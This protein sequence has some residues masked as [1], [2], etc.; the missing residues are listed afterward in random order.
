MVFVG[1]RF[2]DDLFGFIGLGRPPR[3]VWSIARW[4]GALL[5]TMLVFAFIYY[6]TPDV[7]HRSFRWITPG[8]GRRRAAV[9]RS[10]RSA[11]RSTSRRV[12]DVGALYGAFAGAIV[13]VGWLWL[14]NVALLF[15]A[16]L[17]AEIEREKE[18]REG[19]PTARRSTGPPARR[20]P[21]RAAP[22]HVLDRALLRRPGVATPNLVALGL[23]ATTTPPMWL[24]TL[25]AQQV[26]GLS[27]AAAGLLFPP[28]NLAVVAGS[29]L[30]PRV[31]AA[32]GARATMAG[33]LAGVAGGALALL[34]IA[35]G[36]AALPSLAGGFVLLGA[37]PRPRVGR[38]DA[39]RDR[40]ARRRPPGLR[41]RPARDER[42]ARHRARAR[43][44]R[45]G[46]GRADGR[47]GRRPR[48]RGVLARSASCSPP[49]SPAPPPS[50]WRPAAWR[51]PARR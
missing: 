15:G 11:S 3:D 29:L 35:P 12:A 23:T 24:C 13:L 19:V 40:G 30:G 41:L 26:L 50:R 39:A 28:F 31:V 33:G 20:E 43:D 49:R 8:R 2:A 9:A 27:P 45:P 6:V 36:T 18:L 47:A 25:H 37:G 44:R 16:E 10:P 32:A 22:R 14:T 5:V 46:H 17:N 7:Q 48:R 4:P 38:V 21:G 1:G 42:P 34:A 51:A